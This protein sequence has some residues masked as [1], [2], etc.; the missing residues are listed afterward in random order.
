[1]KIGDMFKI[2]KDD[3]R[4]WVVTEYDPITGAVTGKGETGVTY[5]REDLVILLDIN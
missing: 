1:M 5:T 4:V 2:N 3:S